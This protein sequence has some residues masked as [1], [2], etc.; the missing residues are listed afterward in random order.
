MK[1]ISKRLLAGLVAILPVVVTVYLLYWLAT[2]AETFLGRFIQ[3]ILP[4]GWYVPGMG[5]AAGM[6][7][8][9]LVGILMQA[10]VVRTLVSWAERI[11]YRVP[12]IKTVYGS[13][14]DLLSFLVQGQD[15]GLRQVVAV[16]FGESKVIGFVTREDLTDLPGEIGGE[17][18]IAVYL[19]MSYQIGGYTVLVPRSAVQPVDMSLEKATRFILTGGVG[20]GST[21][22]KK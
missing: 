9:F 20:A 17:D 5:V 7:L 10:W 3:M 16:T 15:P 8:V 11:V 13:V 1:M 19:P 21:T 6:L 12:L 4:R 14:R 2:S 22:P 18:I